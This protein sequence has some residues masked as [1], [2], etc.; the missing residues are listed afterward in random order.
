MPLVHR[1]YSLLLAARD[2]FLAP[3]LLVLVEIIRNRW[4]MLLIVTLGP[5]L[6]W[7]HNE[8][9]PKLV[10]GAEAICTAVAVFVFIAIAAI[11]LAIRDYL[12]SVPQLTWVSTEECR[13]IAKGYGELLVE[14]RFS[15][16]YSHCCDV[17]KKKMS[18]DRMR[19]VIDQNFA[20]NGF[21]DAICEVE[22]MPMDTINGENRADAKVRIVLQ[23]S[24][25]QQTLALTFHLLSTENYQITEMEIPAATNSE[26]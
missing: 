21:P 24:R 10:P 19:E 20:A 13:Q 8:P 26:L 4:W 22:E 14:R 3:F 6:M 7:F 23:H 2:V 15:E 11:P 5:L 16:L 25:F 1:K 18:Y 9:F 17:L 12:N